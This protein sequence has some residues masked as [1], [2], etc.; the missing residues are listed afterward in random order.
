MNKLYSVLLLLILVGLAL[1]L[2][3]SLVAFLITGW[4]IWMITWRYHSGFFEGRYY[5][6]HK[7]YG[8]RYLRPV[9]DRRVTEEIA[10]RRRG[11]AIVAL[12]FFSIAALYLITGFIGFF[13]F[14]LG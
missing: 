9:V 7:T 3:L 4:L 13:I 12:F 10:S 6:D 5:T 14:E 11:S 2:L 1:G 8:R